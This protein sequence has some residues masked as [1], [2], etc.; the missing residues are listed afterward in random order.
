MEVASSMRGQIT[1]GQIRKIIVVMR[2]FIYFHTSSSSIGEKLGYVRHPE[3]VAF[4]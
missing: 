4:V 3:L 1:L 2:E